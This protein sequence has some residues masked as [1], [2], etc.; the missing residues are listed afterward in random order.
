MGLQPILASKLFRTVTAL[1]LV[2]LTVAVQLPNVA[3]ADQQLTVVQLSGMD[4]SVI[5]PIVQTLEGNGFR[6]RVVGEEV[7]KHTAPG[8]E[9]PYL[10]VPLSR[11]VTEG[12]LVAFQRHLASGGKIVLIPP[13][14]YPNLSVNR[15]F[16]M[17]GLSVTGSTFVP[18]PLTLNWKGKALP[19][20]EQLPAG[21]S[22]LAISPGNRM[23][24]LATWGN[25]YPAVV[26]TEKGGVL[27]WKWPRQLTPG[28]NLNALRVVLPPVPL[29]PVAEPVASRVESPPSEPPSTQPPAGTAG[30]TAAAPERNPGSTERP[31]HNTRPDANN[32]IRRTAKMPPPEAIQPHVSHNPGIARGNAPVQT[33]QE[34]GMAPRKEKPAQV[35]TPPARVAGVASPPEQGARESAEDE[36]IR[37]IMGGEEKPRAQKPFSFLDPDAASLLAPEFDYGVY[38]KNMRVL[39]DYKRRISDA[40]ETSRQLSLNFPQE[41]VETLMREADQHKRRFEQLYLNNDTQ[42]GLDEYAIAKRLTL[43]ALALTSASPRVEGRAIWLDRGT[44]VDAGSEAE[45][46]KLMQK[47]HQAGIN[48]VF[49]ETV[50]AGFPVYPSKLV[51]RNPLVNGWD[52]LKAA[53]EEGHRLN[54]EVHAWVWVFAVGNRRHNDV[55]GLPSDYPGPILEDAGLMG[56]ALRNAQGGLS[57]DNRQHEFWLS[58]A[59]PRGR[60]FL[61]DLY[62]EIVTNYDVDGLHLDYIRYPFQS[63]SSRMGYEQVGRDGFYRSTGT[64]LDDLDDHK[65]KLWIA[66]KTYQVNTFVQQVSEMA[67]SVRPDI[68]LSAAVFPMKRQSRIVAIQQDWETWIDNGWI[69]ILNPMSYTRDPERLQSIYDYVRRSPQKHTMIYPGIAIRNLDAGE[70]VM[71]LEALRERGSM[72]ATLF[73]G[74]HLDPE[75]INT[76]GNGPFKDRSTIPPHR[77]VVKSIKTMLSEYDQKFTLLQ[78]KGALTMVSPPLVQGIQQGLDRLASVLNGIRPSDTVRVVQAQQQFKALKSATQAWIAQERVTHPFRAQYFE[79]TMLMMDHLL[80]Y[81]ADRAGVTPTLADYHPPTDSEPDPSEESDNYTMVGTPASEAVAPVTP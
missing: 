9:G 52:P 65:T 8:S 47:L 70:L 71:E 29:D 31:V 37:N 10:I 61:L 2:L 36:V 20:S 73:A 60:Q 45:I 3:L 6:A 77:D 54:M 33:P 51:K 38:S 43:Q 79:K 55:A 53:V 30:K 50:N 67:K 4:R 57:V 78:G 26:T 56:E 1:I 13:E 68:R 5:Q 32:D 74:A 34:H 22:I 7:F 42:A 40:L 16:Q 48:V 81:L 58:P 64:S 49:F 35:S 39:D 63:A 27:N 14:S 12:A 66:W 72:G 18:E 15:L 62:R 28:M 24:V 11:Q 17:V 76:L 80:G 46:K 21:S 25:D 19:T 69:D 75:K 44:I 23:N 41:Q 59:S